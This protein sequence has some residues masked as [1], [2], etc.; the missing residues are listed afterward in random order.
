MPHVTTITPDLTPDSDIRVAVVVSRYNAWITDRLR[1]GALDELQR[2]CG[3]RARAVVV[4][5]PG[6]FEVPV[7]AAAAAASG[8]FHAVVALGCIIK[9]ETIHDQVI[10]QAITNEIAAA[11]CRTGVP[12]G[13]G[14]L[15]VN[16]AQQAEARAGGA[17]G[18]KGAEAMSA[19]L[20]T[21]AALK[22][23]AA[24]SP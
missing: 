5:V 2:R 14:I 1:D 16:N 20:E 24:L 21:A 22:A 15:T 8:K 17:A 23:L 18:N 6:S 12:I 10:A 13:L 3:D 19:A 9:G 7:L 11:A 4:P